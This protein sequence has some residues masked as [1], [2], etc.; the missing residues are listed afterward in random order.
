M[1]HIPLKK[2][3]L[4]DRFK[5]VEYAANNFISEKS[6]CMCENPARLISIYYGHGGVRT[7][8][9]PFIYCSNDC[10]NNDAKVTPE[11]KANLEKL[12]FR[13]A[14]S[15]ANYYT[16]HLVEIISK[17]M[18]IKDGRKTQQYLYDFFNSLRTH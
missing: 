16:N 9:E 12:A 13:T 14:I 10:F 8:S 2:R 5:F 3:S 17:C 6:C 18:G 15:G 11:N 7:S 4:S 1:D